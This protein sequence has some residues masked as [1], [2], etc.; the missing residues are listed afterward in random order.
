MSTNYTPKFFWTEDTLE[1]FKD[2]YKENI[3]YYYKAIE[4]FVKY[5]CTL[6]DGETYEDL[7]VDLV[8]QTKG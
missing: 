5:D 4:Q 1:H 3:K 7:M 2:L 8:K 6:E